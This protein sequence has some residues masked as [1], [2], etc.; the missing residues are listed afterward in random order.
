[1][2]EK[3]YITTSIAYANDKPHLG[4][5]LE[6]VQAD[7]IAR[8]QR[9]QG[10]KVFFLAGTDEHGLK[11][12]R[13]AQKAG[14][15]PQ[16]FV[17]RNSQLFFDLKKVL[18]LSFDDFIRT[19]DKKRHYPAVEKFWKK[20]KKAGALKKK[21]YEGLYC[22]G[23]EAFLTPKD[24]VEG[25]CPV[26]HTKPERLKE[27]NWF[28]IMGKLR[29]RVKKVLQ[30]GEIKI[31][32]RHRVKEVLNILNDMPDVS[33]S[34]SRQKLPWG[35]P[36]P[37]DS[38]QTIYV[39]AD[40][41]VNYLSAVGYASGKYKR[42]WP[43][44]LHIVGKDIFRFHAAL[45][46]AMLLAAGE[47]LPRAI[48]VHGFISLA[49]KK[50]SKSAG[51]FVTPLDVAKKHGVDALRY[52]LLKE[53]P[54]TEDGDFSWERFEAIYKGELADNLGNLVRRVLAFPLHYLKGA[55]PEQ[56]ADPFQSQVLIE[57]YQNLMDSF[58]LDR[59]LAELDRFVSRLNVFV[60]KEKPWVSIKTDRKA[61][62]RTV[63]QLL[64]GVRLLAL[65]FYPFIPQSANLIYRSLGLP[66][67]KEE[68][69][70]D[71]RWGSLPSGSFVADQAP[72]LFP[73][74]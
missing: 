4:Y 74:E 64:E 8:Y 13:A 16:R 50:M 46:P 1:M 66:E 7:A 57:T 2:A 52:Y 30:S 67:I 9:L 12:F 71:Y 27:E 60:D 6:V 18:N 65:L 26:H 42:W 58:Q 54:T 63:Y 47:K 55:V 3:F 70:K 53:I 62:E 45:W 21:K 14:L 37:G 43:A 32:P 25:R 22:V 33:F 39:W 41:L 5:G 23:C 17:G 68:K 73:K 19:T 28:F 72:I 40:A 51:H 69:S 24:L 59:T 20:L 48:L 34:R 29:R 31:Y 11:N 36:V 35:I 15:S 10:K 61:F 49:G 44:D 56:A 38:S